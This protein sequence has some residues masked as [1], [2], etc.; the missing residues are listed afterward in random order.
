MPQSWKRSMDQ[1]R[2][3]FSCSCGEAMRALSA[4]DV[5]T[6]SA[7]LHFYRIAVVYNNPITASSSLAASATRLV[8]SGAL[9]CLRPP[10]L[11]EERLEQLPTPLDTWRA[12][13]GRP[14]PPVARAQQPRRTRAKGCCGKSGSVEGI[15]IQGAEQPHPPSFRA[16]Q[17]KGFSKL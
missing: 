9:R 14:E 4:V 17:R 2:R 6:A 13:H 16:S 11:A 3:S 1:H 12:A 5:D 7:C 15:A 8:S 10:R